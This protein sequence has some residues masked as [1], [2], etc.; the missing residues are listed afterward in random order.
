[1]KRK[2]KSTVDRTIYVCICLLAVTMIIAMINGVFHGER[3]GTID[4]VTLVVSASGFI[5]LLRNVYKAKLE[6]DTSNEEIEEEH[7]EVHMKQVSKPPYQPLP[8][9]DQA[10]ERM[11]EANNSRPK[12]PINF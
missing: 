1:M 4:W 10:I 6:E 3:I 12:P 11:Q 5:L 7:R 2:R 8:P 9:K